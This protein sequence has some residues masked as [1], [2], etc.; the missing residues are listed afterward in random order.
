MIHHEAD[1]V[2]LSATMPHHVAAA[3]DSIRMIRALPERA[4][5][6]VIVGGPPFQLDPELWRKI[7]ADAM[8]QNPEDAVSVAKRL[9]ETR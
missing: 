6:P 1:V 5:T 9:V 3:A 8:G 7:G 4:D 2:G